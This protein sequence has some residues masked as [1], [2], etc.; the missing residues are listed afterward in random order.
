MTTQWKHAFTVGI[1]PQLTVAGLTALRMALAKNDQRLL[2]GATT[3]PPPLQCVQDW[4]CE[5][6]CPISFAGWEGNQLETVAQVEEFFARTCAQADELL[7]EVAGSRYFLN[8]WDTT[9]R[10]EARTLLLAEVDAA[11]A[12]RRVPQTAVA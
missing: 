7:G 5:G 2:Q 12:S 11:L 3:C 4:P 8:F 1:A 6:G 9:P 10:A